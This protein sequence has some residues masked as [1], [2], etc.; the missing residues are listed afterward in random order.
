LHIGGG[1]FKFLVSHP[2]PEDNAS[3]DHPFG[4]ISRNE[5]IRELTRENAHTV[6]QVAAIYILEA[7]NASDTWYAWY[8]MRVK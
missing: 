5:G 6:I 3:I 4:K 2:E 1:D 8:D 7:M